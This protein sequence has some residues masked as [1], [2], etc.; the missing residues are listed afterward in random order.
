MSRVVE[1]CKPLGD[2]RGATPLLQAAAQRRNLQAQRD[3]NVI[4]PDDMRGAAAEDGG[5][6]QPAAAAVATRADDAPEA[7]NGVGEAVKEQDLGVVFRR[8]VLEARDAML[9]NG[10][11]VDEQWIDQLLQMPAITVRGGVKGVVGR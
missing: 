9:A 5:A 11:A 8:G 3:M 4:A 10:T 6:A 7:F 1:E 2:G